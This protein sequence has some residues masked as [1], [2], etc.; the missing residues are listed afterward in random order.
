MRISG[1]AKS[2][3]LLSVTQS[4]VERV[5]G[6][7]FLWIT[8]RPRGALSTLRFRTGVQICKNTSSIIWCALHCP[9]PYLLALHPKPG[10][11][12]RSQIRLRTLVMARTVP[13]AL[14]ASFKDHNSNFPIIM[15]PFEPLKDLQ[16]WLN[17]L[18]D[19]PYRPDLECTCCAWPP[20]TRKKAERYLI[21]TDEDEEDK[22]VHLPCGCNYRRS[23]ISS[24]LRPLLAEPQDVK[25]PSCSTVLLRPWVVAQVK[26]DS[27][28]AEGEVKG[29]D[30][31]CMV[32][33]QD[34]ESPD[35]GASSNTSMK[36]SCGHIFHDSC[37][38]KWLSPAPWGGHGN[39][40]PACRMKL[41]GAWPPRELFVRDRDNDEEE[42][43]DYDDDE[44]DGIPLNSDGRVAGYE[45]DYEDVAEDE[46]VDLDLDL[47]EDDDEVD[48]EDDLD[49][50]Q[51]WSIAQGH[52]EFIYEREQLLKRVSQS[53]DQPTRILY[54]AR[55]RV[56]DRYIRLG[57]KYNR[58]HGNPS[59]GT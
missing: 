16:Q 52:Q 40:C 54:R 9:P 17:K 7:S 35:G 8:L 19:V 30:K 22:I 55:I 23:C 41:F 34:F 12:R 4:S 11:H 31:C 33:Y 59:D 3:L 2:S 5:M 47:D 29:D 56:L 21:Y 28:Y 10:T 24:H 36:L 38:V 14:A 39:A 6:W 57:A 58:R 45:D 37:L 50:I 46:D 51:H 20:R 43:E 18:Y 32:C 49:E 15:D 53:G 25:C 27:K 1:N 26:D 48:E 42:E 13:S 44:D